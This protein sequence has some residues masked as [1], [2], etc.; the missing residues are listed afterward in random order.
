MVSS[1]L[2]N[3][4]PPLRPPVDVTMPALRSAAMV[5]RTTTSFVCSIW[6]SVPD[7]VVPPRKCMWIKTCSNRA[8]RVSLAMDLNYRNFNCYGIIAAPDTSL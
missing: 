6:A 1:P 7:V 3:T 8:R 2:A 4:H 5:R